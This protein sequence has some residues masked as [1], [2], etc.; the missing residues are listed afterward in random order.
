MSIGLL[1]ITYSSQPVSGSAWFRIVLESWIQIHISVKSWIRAR[2]CQNL[3]ALEAQNNGVVE[4][5]ETLPV[6]A[7]RLKMETWRVCRSAVTDSHHFDEEQDY[8][9]ADPQ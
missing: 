3:G 6:E 7:W 9:D 8:S 1:D 4:A 5:R 2:I